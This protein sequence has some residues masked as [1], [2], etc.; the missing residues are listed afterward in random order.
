MNEAPDPRHR[1]ALEAS[2][3]VKFLTEPLLSK[4]LG[5][6]NV[7]DLFLWLRNLS[8]MEAGPRGIF[9]HDLAREALTYDLRWRNPEKYRSI[10]SQ[11]RAFYNLRLQQAS[12]KEQANILTDYIFLHR[13]NAIVKP[14]FEQLRRQWKGS[15]SVTSIDLYSEEDRS[16]V[17]AMTQKN[18]GEAASEMLSFWLDRQPD[19]VLVYR[20]SSGDC[21]GFL[22]SLALDL[23]S[24][25]DLEFDPVVRRCWDYLQQESPLRAGETATLFRFWMDRDKH[26]A[27]SRTQSQIF[28]QMV[29]HYIV[30]PG[31]A[32][33]FLPIAYP[34]FFGMIF[35]YA[36]LHRINDLD[37]SENG[38]SFG[39]F[40]HDWRQRPPIAW[41]DVLGSREI[42]AKPAKSLPE[43]HGTRVLVLSKGQFEKA[44]KEA[45]RSFAKPHALKSNPLLQSRIIMDRLSNEFTNEK[46]IEILLA[47][48]GES[49]EKMKNSTKGQKGWRA[50]DKTYLRPAPSQEIAAELLQLPYSTFRR[51]LKSGIDELSQ[52]LW[53]MEI[54]Q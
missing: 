24:K 52:I 1:L 35:S 32:F 37:F 27:I 40:T 39:I 30:T 44:I 46:R 43:E 50:I 28:V 22:L 6:D 4:L 7:H 13:E 38:I 45:L 10:H 21:K 29:R 41:L 33:S 12:L 19:R 49:V 26:H 11:A 23:I 20:G 51:H 14:F 54:G 9:P 34:D 47:V 2:A 3:V 16:A 42:N 18:E 8:F 36:D 53:E 5:Q 17:L 15:Q 31:L 25:D 48:I